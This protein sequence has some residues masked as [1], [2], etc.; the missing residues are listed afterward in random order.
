MPR[1]A[2]AEEQLRVYWTRV[3]ACLVFGAA[4]L[5]VI[6]IDPSGD[7]ERTKWAYGTAGLVLGYWLR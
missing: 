4:A 3:A 2:P 1:S 7:P 5:Y 6:L